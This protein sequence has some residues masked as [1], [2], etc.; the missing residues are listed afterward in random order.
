M[1]DMEIVKAITECKTEASLARTERMKLNQRNRDAFHGRQDWSH[2]QAGQSA[3]FLPK[4]ASSVEQFS[5]FIKRGLTQFGDWFSVDMPEDS[6]LTADDVRE[7]MKS[8]LEVMPSQYNKTTSASLIL[9]DGSKVGL[10]ESLMIIK[11]HGEMVERPRRYGKKFKAW[12]LRWDLIPTEDYYPDPTGRGLYEIH[13]VERDL[14]D[15]QRLAKAG[16]YDESEVQKLVADQTREEAEA[17]N[18]KAERKEHAAPT[19]TFR[20]RVVI[21]EFWGTLLKDDGSVL[22]EN[23][24]CALANDK[25]LIRKPSKNPWWHNQSPFVVTPLFRDPFTV[26]HRALYDQAVPLNE[27]MN[28]LFNLMLDGGLAAVWGIK[29]LRQG[30]LEDERQAADGIPQGTTLLVSD[31]APPGQQVLTQVTTGNIPQDALAM[32]S[33]V[34]REFEAASMTN[35][36]KLGLLPAKKVLATE[37]TEASNNQ[38]VS[39]DAIISDLETAIAELLTKSWMAI[40][41]NADDLEVS[42]VDT[43]A[44]R[45]TALMLARMS[46]K[47]R[48]TLFGEP[49]SFRVHGLSSTMA[50]ARDFQKTMAF[51]QVIQQNPLLLQSFFKTYSQDKLV[52]QMIKQLNMNPT[53]IKRS[54]EEMAQMAQ[55]AQ[56]A[57][58]MNQMGLT[59]EGGVSGEPGMSSDINQE[60]QP[61]AGI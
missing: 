56:D 26:W 30:M 34:S 10:L 7:L 57:Q 59:G 38:A 9:S 17:R 15:L 58:A 60:A 50:R 28:E 42:Q 45:K 37:V 51:L 44:G 21:D 22:A 46:D 55:E 5:A 33:I 48:Y 18:R 36:I 32:F 1:D 54:D 3:E 43:A 39:L 24:V 52:N 53:A 25:Y 35:E 40:M 23:V 49:A 6:S 8:Y 14:F 4:T 12:R 31:N 29:E 47:E 13:R 11:V 41:Q 27:A 61:T 19:P 2:K 20:K 16:I